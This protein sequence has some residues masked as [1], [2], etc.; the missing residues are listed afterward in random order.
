MTNEEKSKK[1]YDFLIIWLI[2][3]MI[4]LNPHS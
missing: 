3:R 1:L 2:M 4:Q